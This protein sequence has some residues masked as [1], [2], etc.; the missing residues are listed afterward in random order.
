MAF[1]SGQ[2]SEFTTPSHPLGFDN[3]PTCGQEIPLDNYEE[4]GGRIAA[5]ERDRVSAITAEVEKVYAIEKASA[6]A[7]AKA[8]LESER[9]QSAVREA[10]VRKEA[11]QAAEKQINDKMEEV[12]KERQTLV[13]GWQQKINEAELKQKTAEQTE[14]RLQAEMEDLRRTSA[15]SLET[16]AAQAEQRETEI[17]NEAKLSAEKSVAKRIAD[18]E[19]A[20]RESEAKA[21]VTAQKAEASRIEADQKEVALQLQLKKLREA[22][23]AEIDQLRKDAAKD[24]EQIK[25]TAIEAAE[26]RVCDTLAAQKKLIAE[27]NT[28]AREAEEHTAK[29]QR[30]LIEQREVMEKS[31]DDAINAEKAKS[32]EDKNKLLT[33]V[34]DLK[35]ALENKTNEEL[36][37][38]AEVDIFEALKAEFDEEGD[39]I[40]RIKKGTPGAD[41]R[42]I[43]KYRGQKCGTI[44]Y[45]SKNHKQW[46]TEHADKLRIDKLADKAEHAILSTHKFPRD[47]RQLDYRDGIL[48]ANPARVVTMATILRQHLLQLHNLRLSQTER[49]SKTAAL[50][51]FITSSQ[52]KDLLDRIDQ[53]AAAL[54]GLLE[55]EI[56]S[57]QKKWKDQGVTI[58]AIQKAKVDLACEIDSIIGASTTDNE[59]SEAS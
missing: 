24:A 33:Q 54:L 26:L 3:C 49:E 52:C 35:R 28:K 9:Q 25:K 5:R 14:A 19:A 44:L 10:R 2:T 47:T 45:D 53:R 30:D 38:G 20:Q 59:M 15:K 51:K 56:K 43:V 42:H 46:R 58:R 21:Q 50:Y 6:E 13:G 17:R 32:F 12:Q 29:V 55:E 31:K 41:I 23:E 16:M 7:K 48:L 1:Q 22:N 18:L 40:E 57:H 4:I 34:S 8:D 36:G 11:Q 37:E 27:A 39:K